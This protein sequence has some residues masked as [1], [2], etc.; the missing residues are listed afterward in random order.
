MTKAKKT[1]SYAK[2]QVIMD[3]DLWKRFLDA[4]QAM[5]T[6]TSRPTLSEAGRR[7]ITRGIE[8]MASDKEKK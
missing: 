2:L 1:N 7:I 6:D 8:A 5:A 4:A 3:L